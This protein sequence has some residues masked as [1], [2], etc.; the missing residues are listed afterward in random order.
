MSTQTITIQLPDDLYRS[1]NQLARTTKRPLDEILQ[2]SLTH[3]LPPLDDVSPGEAEALAQLSLLDDAELWQI[4]QSNLSPVKQT[5]LEALLLAQNKG[6]LD[7]DAK[8]TL[9]K[10]QNEYGRLLVRQSHAWL[11]LARRG[12]KVPVQNR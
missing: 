6:E 7:E 9:I 5:R 1:A 2:D 10:L 3:T 4:A 11:L 8:E 12:Y